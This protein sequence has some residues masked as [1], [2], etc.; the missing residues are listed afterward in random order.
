MAAYY[1]TTIEK[2][3]KL[4]KE[5]K[6]YWLVAA[7]TGQLFTYLLGA[8][9]YHLLLRLFNARRLLTVWE[10]FQT[11]MVTL[12]LNQVI[13]SGG[14]SG[15]TYIFHTL[16]RRGVEGGKVLSLIVTELLTFYAAMEAVMLTLLL[17]GLTLYRLPLPQLLV[18]AIG[19]AVYLVF[20]AAVWFVGRRSTLGRVYRRLSTLPLLKRL[21]GK[22]KTA[23]PKGTA[24]R[25][26]PPPRELLRARSGELARAVA[27]QVGVLL[28]D[29]FTV[30]ALFRGLGAPVPFAAAAAGFILTGIVSLLPVS[31]GALLLYE[32]SMTYFYTA[33]GAPVSAAVI[34]TLLF[35][36]L[37]FWLPM[38]V[39]L[40]IY[41]RFRRKE[42]GQRKNQ[43]NKL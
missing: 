23:L 16:T 40:I 13:P 37:S 9:V 18:L 42:G 11:T 34:V 33:L 35:R 12:F 36:V 43:Y 32:G 30:F 15:N 29:V 10:L 31:P 2:D 19:I 25:E 17:T 4:F 21:A 5:V 28:A 6:W 26:A 24:A 41:R 8:V 1:S 38:P 20:A 27:L 14:V 7:L 39:G 22:L 3:L